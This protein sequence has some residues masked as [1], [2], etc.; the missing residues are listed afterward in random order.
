MRCLNTTC[1]KYI[2]TDITLRHGKLELILKPPLEF[3]SDTS[4]FGRIPGTPGR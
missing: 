4:H 2:H 1:K 3:K